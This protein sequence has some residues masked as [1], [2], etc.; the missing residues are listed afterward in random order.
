MRKR[1]TEIQGMG[2]EARRD[3]VLV[4]YQMV[5]MTGS[6][7]PEAA[8]PCGSPEWGAGAQAL[9]PSSTAL[10]GTQQRAGSEAE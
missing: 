6:A 9:V 3:A 7:N 10:P 2:V 5:T 4:L 1:Q 8:S